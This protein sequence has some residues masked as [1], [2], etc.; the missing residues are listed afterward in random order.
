MVDLY[1]KNVFFAILLICPFRAYTFV[2]TAYGL[3]PILTP[4]M[5]EQ[6]RRRHPEVFTSE[7]ILE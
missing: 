5:E 6:Q 7:R 4:M 1:M 3:G 2:P